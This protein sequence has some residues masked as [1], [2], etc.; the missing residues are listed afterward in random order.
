MTERTIPLDEILIPDERSRELD[1]DWAVALA[2]LIAKQ[3]L[4][5][6]VRLRQTVEGTFVLVAGLHRLEAHRINR[7]D[8][9]RYELSPAQTKDEG[10]MEEVLENLGRNELNALDRCHHLY[11]LKLVYETLYPETRHGAASPKTKSLRLSE[12]GE[13]RPQI[14]GFAQATADAIGLGRRSIELGVQIWSDL[15]PDCRQRLGAMDIRKK[16]SELR[17]LAALDA[18]KQRKVL[19]LIASTRAADVQNVASALEVLDT[20][21][22]ARKSD[23]AY[24]SAQTVLKK[25]PDPDFDRLVVENADRIIASLKR[26]GRIE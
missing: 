9:I 6:P 4:I 3:G 24:A 16:Q 10:R 18:Q 20:G 21:A 5:H 22:Q 11:D 2:A 14:F 15:S 23:K 1:H 7:A 13:E 26:Q 19:D 12:D 25:L 8:S 17:Q